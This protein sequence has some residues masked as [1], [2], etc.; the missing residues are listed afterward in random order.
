MVLEKCW[1][2][3]HGSYAATVGGLPDEVLRAF[4]GAPSFYNRI[5]SQHD[6]Q[7][8]LWHNMLRDFNNGALLCCGTKSDKSVED[9]GFV[10]GH[11]YTIVHFS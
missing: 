2:K 5:P 9:Y 11:A 6:K 8:Q 1:A 4:S 10:L 3:L 7:E